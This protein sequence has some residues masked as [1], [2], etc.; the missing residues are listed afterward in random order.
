MIKK[1]IPK[2]LNLPAIPILSGRQ[3]QAEGFTLIELLLTI[4]I[5]GILL[6][7]GTGGFIDYTRTARLNAAANDLVTMLN[8][9]KS[10][11]ISQLK[12][13]TL[14]TGFVLD[15]YKVSI[16]VIMK[17]YDLRVRCGGID[18]SPAIVTKTLPNDIIFVSAPPSFLF[19]V[20]KGGVIGSGTITING[21]GKTKTVIVDT[22]GNIR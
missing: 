5:I 6:A 2:L 13:E 21:F 3:G 7:V 16:N 1:L 15:G 19:P 17:T 18:R 14:C 20:L 9:A 11:S 12:Y 22:A 10:N 8:L 4:S